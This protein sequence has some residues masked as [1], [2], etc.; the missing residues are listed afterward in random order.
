MIYNIIS[1]HNSE[2][3]HH[4]WISLDLHRVEDRIVCMTIGNMLKEEKWTR[5][6]IVCCLF[7][8]LIFDI[9]NLI[10]DYFLLI[11]SFNQHRLQ[12]RNICSIEIESQYTQS[13]QH[14]LTDI[15]TLKLNKIP[16]NIWCHEIWMNDTVT[17]NFRNVMAVRFMSGSMFTIPYRIIN[18]GALMG[19]KNH[20]KTC[21]NIFYCL[22]NGVHPLW[23]CHSNLTIAIVTFYKR[24]IVCRIASNMAMKECK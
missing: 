14:S 1:C 3:K 4:T 16:H 15:D 10:I 17:S 22:Y 7:D 21:H 11:L 20:L 18:N 9:H 24:T 23:N 19:L 13:P 8:I 5:T 6:I 12:V 2:E